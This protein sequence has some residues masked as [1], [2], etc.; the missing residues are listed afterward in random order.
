M[1]LIKKWLTC[2]R[3]PQDAAESLEDVDDAVAD[4][5]PLPADDVLDDVGQER[6]QGSGGETQDRR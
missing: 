1:K 5:E 4:S 3:G 2:C 6:A